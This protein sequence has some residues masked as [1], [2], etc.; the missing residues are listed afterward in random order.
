[1][2]LRT[3]AGLFIFASVLLPIGF[4]NCSISPTSFVVGESFNMS[5]DLPMN[6]PS[7]VPLTSNEEV[8]FKVQLMSRHQVYS[9]LRAILLS[10]G[11]DAGTQAEVDWV[12][13]QEILANMST[14]GGP[15]EMANPLYTDFPTSDCR[16]SPANA[17]V[18]QYIESSI[19]REASRL[20]ACRRSIGIDAVVTAF[21]N[22][23]QTEVGAT[24]VEPSTESVRAIHQLFFLGQSM[25]QT[26]LNQ[27]L[28]LYDEMGKQGESLNDRWR[29]LFLVFCELPD[30]QYF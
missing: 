1:M 3:T 8:S 10:P 4:W 18:A 25:D 23:I 13:D 20:Q 6:H 30:W 12:L 14:F 17:S 9:H 22:R 5:S 16:S 24:N 21:R 29:M 11:L 15:C 7:L 28:S 27:T 19:S 2:K 26:A